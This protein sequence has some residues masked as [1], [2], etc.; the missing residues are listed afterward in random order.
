MGELTYDLLN[1]PCWNVVGR[2]LCFY[3]SG[4]QQLFSD[5]A[6][7]KNMEVEGYIGVPLF[8][9]DGQATGI[10]VGLNR[11]PLYDSEKI[12]KIFSFYIDRVSAELQ[13]S[14]FELAMMKLSQAVEQSPASVVITSIS[15][16]IEYV[17]SK[18]TSVTGYTLEEVL[19]KNPRIL[20]SGKQSPDFYRELW[21]TISSG[22]EWVGE[23]HNR[24]KNGELYWE[25]AR[26]SPLKNAEGK[27]INYLAA[28][29]DITDLMQAEMNY[30]H[31]I[32]QS[33]IGIRIVNQTGSTVYANAAFLELFDNSSLAEYIATPSKVRY[34]AESLQEHEDRK[35]I[36][37]EGRDVN[38]Y[39]IAIRRKN[40]D[41]R[42]IKVWRKDVLWNKE[43]HIQVINQDITR[44]KLL[45]N[46]LVNAKNKAEESDRLKS[47]F[48]ANMSHEIRTPMNG[49]LGFAELLKEPGLSGDE[50]RMYIDLI[51][52]SGQRMLNII[53]DIIDI[54]KI[55]AG[56]M[57][58]HLSEININEQ[59]EFIH[60]FFLAE[61]KAKGLALNVQQLPASDNVTLKTDKEKLYAV[62]AN[63]VKNALKFTSRGTVELGCVHRNNCLEFFVKDTG[64]GIASDR[65]QAI[66]ERFVQADIEDK[67][68]YQGAGLGLT[69]SKNYVEMLGGKIWLESTEGVGSTFYFTLPLAFGARLAMP[70]AR[71]PQPSVSKEARKLKIL[72][73]ED[74]EVSAMLL[75]KTI[76]AISSELLFATN[77]VEAI[78]KC[79]E[80]SDIDLI[81]MDIRMPVMGGYEATRKIRE[82]NK[83]VVILAQTAFGLTGDREKAE[84]AGCND[85]I[86]KPINVAELKNKIA[87]LLNR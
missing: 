42:Y 6:L 33:P 21:Q 28:K 22:K 62:L 57:E 64:I 8:G 80:N 30:R 49:I 44:E 82:F 78:Q 26:I 71:I 84:E 55:E 40:G 67:M 15:G 31:S 51:N 72:V 23:F 5:D 54:S 46:D 68:A 25:S 87:A 27:I 63:L 65:Q 85:Y 58:V 10:M 50:Q 3:P 79:R 24:K 52:K 56:V 76:T 29:E 7:L 13:R 77:G 45:Y 43:R 39:D 11:R 17:N 14:K 73:V 60:H 70:D 47:A 12:K 1:T 53:R 36:R 38:E 9:K 4:V 81:L 32:D 41:I 83:D 66:F 61:A 35:M 69:I 74:D 16:E 59:F 34:T 20:K 2:Q 75:K 19:G 18:F 48:L 37:K 86:S